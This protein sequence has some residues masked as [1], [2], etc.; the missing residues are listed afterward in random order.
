MFKDILVPLDG[1][2]RSEQALTLAAH[3][4]RADHSTIHLMRSVELMSIYS[5]QTIGM[6]ERVQQLEEQGAKNY[7]DRIK[8]S[9]LL[10]HISTM[11]SVYVGDASSAILEA[12]ARRNIDLVVLCSHGYT[13]LKHWVLGSVAQKIARACPVPVL[14]QR[15]EHPLPFAMDAEGQPTFR[16]CITLDGS[17][18]AEAVIE[19][20]IAIAS[21]CASGHRAE[22]HLLRV[23]EPINLSD[24]EAFEEIYHL[25]LQDLVRQ[26]AQEYLQGVVKRLELAARACENIKIIGHL[27]SGADI[28][29]EIIQYAENG[30]A[31][32]Y[33]TCQLLAMTTHGRNKIDRWIF[34]S[35]AERVLN[36]T[37]L[38]LLIMRPPQSAAPTKAQPV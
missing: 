23:I 25:N 30:G 32:Q 37:K 13:G 35:I 20:A 11:T 8:N 9:A 29:Q 33:P 16:V 4:A 1:S 21:A 15:T 22:V 26:Q 28:A 10:E 36:R 12:V 31:S 34:G 17:E 27:K 5:M 7:L 19:P 18:Q 2:S 6:M 38:P 24:E 14:I 3:I